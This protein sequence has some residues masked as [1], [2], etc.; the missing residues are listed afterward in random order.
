MTARPQYRIA[1][2]RISA[3]TCPYPQLTGVLAQ[4]HGWIRG[5]DGRIKFSG[6]GGIAG[7]TVTLPAP[8]T[9]GVTINLGD[10]L[11]N[12]FID[13][14]QLPGS[15]SI[16]GGN[17]T[18]DTRGFFGAPLHVLHEGIKV[19]VVTGEDLLANTPD[20]GHDWIVLVIIIIINH[21]NSI[22]I[23]AVRI[24]GATKPAC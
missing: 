21:G 12:L 3:K 4:S 22:S 13:G 2:D 17:G 6:A 18:P 5:A 14:V 7:G 8:V 15:L 20:F 9:G 23:S 1:I 16:N 19:I 10:G 24:R 11:D